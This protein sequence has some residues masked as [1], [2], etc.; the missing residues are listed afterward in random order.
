[1]A[2][3]TLTLWC[4]L[5]ARMGVFTLKAEL[6][7]ICFAVLQPELFHSLQSQLNHLWCIRQ[8]APPH[9]HH[10]PCYPRYPRNP[11]RPLP[12][13]LRYRVS[14]FRNDVSNPGVRRASPGALPEVSGAIQ[15]FLPSHMGSGT[16]VTA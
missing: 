10:H 15:V 8:G 6:E 7:D 1:M 14:G 16:N 11:R 3:E 9:L 12:P 2:Q 13:S 4:S 5:A